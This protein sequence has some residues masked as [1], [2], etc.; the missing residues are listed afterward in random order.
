MVIVMNANN[1]QIGSAQSLIS[2]TLHFQLSTLVDINVRISHYKCQLKLTNNSMVAWTTLSDQKR[3]L[4]IL[5]Y[6]WECNS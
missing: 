2:L 4:V 5:S 1:C 6:F 3:L